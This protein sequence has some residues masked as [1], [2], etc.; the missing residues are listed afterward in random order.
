MVPRYRKEKV[1]LDKITFY[2]LQDLNLFF[3]TIMY[4]CESWTIKKAEP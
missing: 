3:S 1:F 2:L 4:G